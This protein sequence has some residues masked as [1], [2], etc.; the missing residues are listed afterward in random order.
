MAKSQEDFLRELLA[1]FRI[2]A[3]E[4]QQAIT[5][6]MLLLE[7][8]PSQEEYQKV[9]ETIF[10]EFHSLKGAARAVNQGEVERL[11]QTM[12]GVFHQIKEG[13]ISLTPTLL[14]LLFNGVDMLTRLLAA[15]N[16]AGQGSQ[17][18]HFQRAVESLLSLSDPVSDASPN[19]QKFSVHQAEPT[20]QSPSTT[21]VSVPGSPDPAQAQLPH[22]ESVRIATAKL[23]DILR[24]SE[25]FISARAELNYFIE[26]L[27]R[28]NY[29]GLQIVQQNLEKFGHA[30]SRQVDELIHDVKN[31]LL[32]PFSSL[33]DFLPKMGRDLAREFGKEI[34]FTVTG[35]ET[36]TD[37]RILEG[38][39]DPLIHLIRNCV[40]HGIEKPEV[41]IKNGK[42]AKGAI[43]ITI[44]QET[45]RMVE[46]I[47]SDDG[48]GINREKLKQSALKNS[49]ASV[50]NLN[51]MSD[52]ELLGLIFRSGISTSPLIT[53][54]SGRG[55][56]MAIVA[57]KIDDLGG[58]VTV[59]SEPGKGTRFNISLPLS[60]STFRGVVVRVFNQFFVLPTLAVERA[61]Y[62]ND[63]DIRYVESR[64]FLPLNGENIALIKLSDALGIKEPGQRTPQERV[65]PVLVVMAAHRKVAFHVDEILSE[66]EGI[67]KDLGPQLVHVRNLAGATVLGNGKVIPILHVPEVIE[68]AL[69][70]QQLAQNYIRQVEQEESTE[71][72]I[73]IL[74]A[75]D[76][77]T[78]RMLLRNILE[79]AGFLVRTAVDGLE[80]FQFLQNELFDLVVSDVE[81]PGMNGFELT[82]KIRNN[83]RL[84]SVPVVLVTALGSEWDRQ[85]GLEAGAN[86][87]IVKSNFEQ[88]NLV[89]TVQRLV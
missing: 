74:V 43:K 9:V 73:R 38:L 80:A 75:E 77:I 56:G 8:Q 5:Q 72:Q 14:D 84:K 20:L 41:R 66:Q 59:E 70:L 25:A 79:N 35:A 85:R 71:K 21:A 36:E 87:Y 65:T 62:L 49:V 76:S 47:V 58:G 23:N 15:E 63:N 57:A 50:Q 44:T 81:M 3:A 11:C 48:S 52:R 83:E 29:P 82:L 60:L 64:P 12:E 45:G 37:R 39:K 54:L 55:L 16:G 7:Q 53:D 51:Q 68:S 40:D 18:A 69:N 31:A 6:G 67:V 46:V 86:A 89:E 13:Q 30:F 32:V 78:S 10:R 88:S 2:E 27:N 17:I 19:E 28:V 24:Q 4:H 61:I 1:D 34:E 22:K 33:T 26:E 42:T